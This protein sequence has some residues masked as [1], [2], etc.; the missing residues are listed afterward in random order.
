MTPVEEYRPEREAATFSSCFSLLKNPFILFLVLGIFLY[1]GAEVGMNSNIQNY[2]ISQFG[3]P[4]EKASLGISLFFAALMI[5][6]FVGA[7]L[8]NFVKPGVFLLLTAVLSL[9]GLLV[10][11]AAPS[12]TFALVAIFIAGPRFWKPVPADFF[13]RHWPYAGPLQRDCRPDGDGDRRW[14]CCSAHYGPGQQ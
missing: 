5:S 8:L 4:L 14:C 1:V 7:I 9:V 6:R 13:Y 12:A 11:I 10:M 3:I 2:L